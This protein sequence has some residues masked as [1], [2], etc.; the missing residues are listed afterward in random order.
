[1]LPGLV[2]NMDGPPRNR[3]GQPAKIKEDEHAEMITTMLSRCRLFLKTMRTLSVDFQPNQWFMDLKIDE[4]EMISWTTLRSFLACFIREIKE[5]TDA[6]QWGEV[7]DVLSWLKSSIQYVHETIK[8]KGKQDLSFPR[9]PEKSKEEFAQTET[10][11]TTIQVKLVS[12]FK[13]TEK[14][15]DRHSEP[16]DWSAQSTEQQRSE[17]PVKVDEGRTDKATDS[18]SLKATIKKLEHDKRILTNDLKQSKNN[19][20]TLETRIEKMTSEME[21][22]D[23]EIL[24]RRKETND[25]K[26]EKTTLEHRAMEAHHEK[27]KLVGEKTQLEKHFSSL[28]MEY[29][30]LELRYSKLAGAKMAHENPNIADLSDPN[31]PVK[32]AEAFSEL[33]DNEWTDGFGILS[34]QFGERQTIS[35]LKEI[36][37][38]VNDYCTKSAEAIRELV[39]T[40]LRDLT[41]P[42]SAHETGKAIKQVVLK[43]QKQKGKPTAEK[44]KETKTKPAKQTDPAALSDVIK[45]KQ[46]Q[47][48]LKDNASMFTDALQRG[49]SQYFTT[50]KVGARISKRK[51]VPMPY[52]NKCVELCWLMA[53]QSPP[54]TIALDDAKKQEMPFDERRYK[55]FT[56]KGGTV[57]FVVWP[58]IRL[59]EA[60][61]ILCKGVAQGK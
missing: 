6:Q 18:Q 42:A 29:S 51:T 3:G 17:P 49:F 58:V 12:L 56:A 27:Q 23:Q 28:K 39:V 21:S 26:T 10:E 8:Q 48:C 5:E 30:E 61:G 47:D 16:M 4:S 46:I 41:M 60:D 14:N 25:L 19:L 32:L 11:L 52:I 37:E 24:F 35:I 2:L 36:L 57:D 13:A 53:I 59:A 9:I 50:S 40:E 43:F 1:M 31:R 44:A 45:Q 15:E 54:V 38:D 20:T 55:Y 7:E 34:K 22:K 33:Y